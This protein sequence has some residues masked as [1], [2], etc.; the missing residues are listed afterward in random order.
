MVAVAAPASASSPAPWQPFH[1]APFTEAAGDVCAFALR[2]DI[3]TDHE[4]FRTLA[5]YPDGSPREQEFVGPLVI[6]Y[7]NLS[8]GASVERNLTGTAYFF[9]D[10]D[11]TIHGHGLGHIGFTVHAGNVTPPPGEY[12]ITGS[13]DFVLNADGTRTFS[14]QGGTVENLCTTLA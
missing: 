8:T 12:I 6:R 2:A 5:S 9:F 14:V 3:V 4:L 1:A 7:T 10:P 11:G 13:Y